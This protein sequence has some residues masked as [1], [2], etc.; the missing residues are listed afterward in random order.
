[1]P[2]SLELVPEVLVVNVVVVLHLR[3]FHERSQQAR[4]AIGRSLL[5]VG[6]AALHILAQQLGRPVSVAEVL[7]RVVDVVRQIA[8]GLA[9][10]LD[11]RGLALKPVLKIESITR[12]GFASGATERTSTRMLRSLPIG[13]R[14]IDPRSTAEAL[15]WFGASKC[16]SSRR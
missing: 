16:G 3:R 9:Q 12:Y 5:Q 15:I 11:L 13:M 6:V 8:F 4:T 1:M 7:Q 14:I 10:V 2:A